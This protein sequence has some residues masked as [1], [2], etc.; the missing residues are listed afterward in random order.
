MIG[1]E[2]INISIL[3]EKTKTEPHGLCGGQNGSGGAIRIV[4]ERFIPPKGLTKLYPGDELIL[5]LPGG[6]GFGNPT[7]R[8]PEAIARDRLLGYV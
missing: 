8:N 7:E 4:P 3:T 6:G 2:P 5:D 1:K